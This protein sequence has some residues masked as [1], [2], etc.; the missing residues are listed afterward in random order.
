M[1]RIYLINTLPQLPKSFQRSYITVSLGVIGNNSRQLLSLRLNQSV[2]MGEVGKQLT[3]LNVNKAVDQ[4]PASLL[5]DATPVIV[6]SVTYLVNKSIESWK[7]ARVVPLYKADES[8]D[9]TNYCPISI[10]PTLSK[11]FEHIVHQ[12]LYSYL[13]VN[14]LIYTHQYGF[15]KRYSTENA[16]AQINN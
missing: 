12:Q 3:L 13:A 15:R 14:K 2:T 8:M 11:I 1:L 5:K 6:E 9:L 4:I 7:L 10:L 16:V